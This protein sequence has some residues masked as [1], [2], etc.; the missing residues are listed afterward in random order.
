M[1]YEKCIMYYIL[2]NIGDKC[3]IKKFFVAETREK[4]TLRIR[5]L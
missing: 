3:V 2:Y 1:I 4:E 5:D